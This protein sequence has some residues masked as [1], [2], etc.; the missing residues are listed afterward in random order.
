MG[1]LNDSGPRIVYIDQCAYGELLCANPRQEWAEVL[2]LLRRGIESDRIIVPISAEHLL[3]T[4]GF[5][6]LSV[7]EERLEQMFKLS[8]CTMFVPPEAIAARC[9]FAKVRRRLIKRSDVIGQLHP[10]LKHKTVQHF[11]ERKKA[12]DEN[13]K[14]CHLLY[15]SIVCP[16]GIISEEDRHITEEMRSRGERKMFDDMLKVLDA[17]TYV[18]PLREFLIEHC[19]RMMN[20][21]MIVINEFLA[22]EPTPSDVSVLRFLLETGRDRDV[23]VLNVGSELLFNSNLKQK[24]REQGDYYDVSRLQVA[25]PYS[26]LV[27]TDRKQQVAIQEQSLD[28]RYRTKVFSC[29][30]RD[31]T[32]IIASLKELIA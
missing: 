23:P 26:D 6:N 12:A 30:P 10:N 31:D 5:K 13:Y 22:L 19:K 7:A 21:E 25:I 11:A 14:N 18:G 3:E 1:I 4:G 20:V 32:A 15:N 17:I 27:V 29:S 24:R 8:R 9:L 2:S 16:R 28:V